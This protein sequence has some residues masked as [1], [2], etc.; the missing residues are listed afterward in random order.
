LA[1]TPLSALAPSASRVLERLAPPPEAI[2]EPPP[3]A[4]PWKL[5]V[6]ACFG[7]AAL[8][9]LLP[10]V[11]TAGGDTVL[12]QG[13]GYMD[14]ARSKALWSIYEAP[15]SI[16]RRGD[17]VDKP[18]IGIPYLY[19]SGGVLLAQALDQTGDRQAADQVINQAGQVAKSVGMMD[20]FN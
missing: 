19:V 17:W 12:V 16:A 13:E 11:P 7:L 6:L 20:V 15:A 5:L 18:S 10:S 8:S 14:V 2:D 1:L 9:L 4:R 3:K